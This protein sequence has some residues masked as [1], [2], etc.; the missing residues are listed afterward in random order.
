M[1]EKVQLLDVVI[2]WDPACHSIYWLFPVKVR[3]RRTVS[4]NVTTRQVIFCT[5][6]LHHVLVILYMFML[7]Q[8]ITTSLKRN[9]L[10]NHN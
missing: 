3:Q 1:A 8:N 2:S 10:S 4:I 7:P 9:L 6:Y 5:P